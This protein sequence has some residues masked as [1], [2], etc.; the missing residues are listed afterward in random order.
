MFYESDNNQWGFRE[1]KRPYKLI[2]FII[3]FLCLIGYAVYYWT[4]VIIPEM[5]KIVRI[6]AIAIANRQMNA[7]LSNIVETWDEGSNEYFLNV[8]TDEAGEVEFV[9]TNTY[10]INKL[11]TMLSSNLQKKYSNLEPEYISIPVG[12]IMGSKILSQIGPKIEV[13]VLIQGI[14]GLSYRTEFETEGINQT[15]YKLYIGGNT[16]I[17]VLFP[18]I[19]KI[20]LLET[21]F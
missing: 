13:G 16:E 1:K 2:I 21:V 10:E 12:T 9:Q 14:S 3:L 5:D 4:Q 18:F 20:Y 7:S 6:K 8:V 11:L 19:K 17:L 15:K